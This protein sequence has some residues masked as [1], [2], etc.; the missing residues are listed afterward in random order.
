MYLILRNIV[1]AL[2]TLNSI[3]LWICRCIETSAKNEILTCSIRRRSINNLVSCWEGNRKVFT[4]MK[5]EKPPGGGG[6]FYLTCKLLAPSK[7][8]RHTS[9]I[10]QWIHEKNINTFIDVWIFVDKGIINKPI[11]ILITKEETKVWTSD[12]TRSTVYRIHQTKENL[13]SNH[14]IWF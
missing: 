11:S 9:D 3:F 6:G 2:R 10:I 7:I 13:C 14:Y 1:R 5:C 8:S 12:A 4:T